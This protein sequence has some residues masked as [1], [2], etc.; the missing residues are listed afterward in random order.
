MNEDAP[1]YKK[2][3]HEALANVVRSLITFELRAAVLPLDQTK[4]LK[5]DLRH[6]LALY[7]EGMSHET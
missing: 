7:L 3:V 4:D 6:V 5:E 1:N 2:A